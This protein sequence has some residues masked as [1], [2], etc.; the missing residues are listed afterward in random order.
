[1]RRFIKLLSISLTILLTIV[2]LLG[3][4]LPWLSPNYFWLLGFIGFSFPYIIVVFIVVIMFWLFIKPKYALFLLLV[5]CC[6]YKQINAFFAF[7][8]NTTF[9]KVKAI[10]S[11]RI[12]SWNIGNL[13]GK[14]QEKNAKKHKPEELANLIIEQS[15]DVICLQEFADLRNGLTQSKVFTSI[16]K[17][18]PYFYFPSWTIGQYRHRSGNVI[19]SKTP[20]LLT[21][22]AVFENGENIIKADIVVNADTVSFYTTHFDSYRFSRNE[23]EEID[24]DKLDEE[25]SKKNWKNI[26]SKVK[27]TLNIHNIEANI[28]NEVIKKST[29]PFIFC[30]DMNEVPNNYVY[31]KIRENKQDAFLQKGFGMGKTFNSLTAALRIDYIMPNNNFNVLQFNIIDNGL[32]DHA[33]LVADVELKK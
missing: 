20:I 6:G 30:A 13:S 21:D 25:Q 4:A 28:V 3:C 16:N 27:H 14:T 12:I 9:N 29:H 22:S 15:A 24:G 31:W 32:S 1:M 26:F 11:I 19:F 10:N 5:L 23:F 18:Y 2:Y 7:N 8:A 33:M 17:E